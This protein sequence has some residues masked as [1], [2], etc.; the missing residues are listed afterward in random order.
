[1]ALSDIYATPTDD[2]EVLKKRKLLASALW[3]AR[4]EGFS[5]PD[6]FVSE[7]GFTADDIRS[8]EIDVSGGTGLTAPEIAS[9][10]ERLYSGKYDKPMSTFDQE[11][12]EARRKSEASGAFGGEGW[13]GTSSKGFV[14]TPNLDR[15][16]K[17]QEEP[18]GYRPMEDSR[19][20]IASEAGQA[21]RIAQKAA[22]AGIDPSK[23]AT[24]DLRAMGFK[25]GGI[26]TQ[27]ERET[28]SELQ[29]AAEE[30]RR[31]DAIEKE[32]RLRKE[33]EERQKKAVEES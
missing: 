7:T 22:R 21:R 10:T 26:T 17:M 6:A 19:R 9:F 20:L 28:R 23:Y 14:D 29:K 33:E 1:M 3:K 4:Q 8:N 13:R 11:E 15:L 18:V 32:E 31:K 27:A 5:A 2:E 25:A 16:A 24:D 30:Q 12:Q